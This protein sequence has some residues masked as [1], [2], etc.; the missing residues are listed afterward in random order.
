MKRWQIAARILMLAVICGLAGCGEKHKAE[1]KDY[2]ALVQKQEK[3][4]YID[5]TGKK[6]IDFLYEDA[7]N[8]S[9]NGLAYVLKD[10]KYGYISTDGEMVIAPQFDRSYGFSHGYAVIEEQ[11]KFGAID[12]QGNVVIEPKY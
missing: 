5:G 3:F 9:E 11:G 6:V 2:Y 8:F 1:A 12:T 7:G 4:G 10:G